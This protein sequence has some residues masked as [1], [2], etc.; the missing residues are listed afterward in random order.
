[1]S[2]TT[3]DLLLDQ[4]TSFAFDPTF[5]STSDVLGPLEI[6]SIDL[7]GKDF[8]AV[9]GAFPNLVTAGGTARIN[10]RVQNNGFVSS[11]T[12]AV[13]FYI[14]KI[15]SPSSDY[16]Y[17]DTR[18]FTNLEAL[19]ISNLSTIDIKLPDAG[20]AFWSGIGDGDYY[21][22]MAIDT[23]NQV[24]ES[25]ES[26]NQSVGRLIDYDVITVS[27]TQKKP[28]L[29][30]K[31]FDVRPEPLNA[32]DKFNFD[33]DIAN[34]GGPT[35]KDI[36]VAFYLSK[37]R[38]ITTTDKFLIRTTLAALQA[39]SST[40]TR[41][42]I[43]DLTLP[44]VG[45]AYWSGDGTYFMGMII[46]PDNKIIESNEFDNSNM[47]FLVDYDDVIINGTQRAN[48]RGKSFDVKPE[49]L[50]A[51]S[52]FNFDFNIENVGGAATGAFT[53]SFYLSNDRN[54][55][56]ADKLL[57]TTTI[58]NLN[59][60]SSTDIRK[61]VDDLILP[62]INDS[63]WTGDGTYYVG[64]VVD[65]TNSVL[66][67][68]EF[69]NSNLGLTIDIDDVF[70]SGTQVLGTR[71]NDDLF[72]TAGN[73][74]FFGL[75]GDDDIFGF[76]GNDSLFGERGD[77]NLYGGLGNDLLDGGA[78]DDFLWG[79]DLTSKLPGAGEIDILTGGF[80]ANTFYLGSETQTFYLDFN[81][82]SGNNG[83]AQ[84]T[85]FSAAE[86]TIVLNGSAGNYALRAT[87]GGLPSGQG[88]YRNN[89]LIAIVQTNAS[90][91]LSANYFQYL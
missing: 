39:N 40:G 59:A 37:D 51:G 32:G 73:D 50:K 53:V 20:N 21:I 67:T 75:R 47:G 11:G 3:Q 74:T 61:M 54:I 69:D 26:N 43:D 5:L 64:M 2:S 13:G 14:S 71:G 52:Q 86:D 68:N 81:G 89:D 91:S 12:F 90:L 17:L 10:F 60:K 42:M 55:T 88:I 57:T 82:T 65:S 4:D 58:A 1:M 63:Y 45:D 16:V 18:T 70:I 77:D 23:N 25:N 49:P 38:N 80:G 41:F 6:S 79:V 34:L 78:G 30:G 28:N 36:E 19:S 15:G 56:S 48:L 35:G 8:D 72:G 84:I 83:Y 7:V 87:T 62:G 31:L 9:P 33:F 76:G 85:D 27:G 46:D 44:G 22:G 66:E 29:T 24:I